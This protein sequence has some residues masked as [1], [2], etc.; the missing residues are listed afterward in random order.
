MKTKVKP[1]KYNM[2]IQSNGTEF[3][4]M[5]DC[6]GGNC[7]ICGW[8]PDVDKERKKNICKAFHP[9]VRRFIIGKGSFENI[10]RCP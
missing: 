4:R 9:T 7:L 6:D 10:Q 2:K 5:V 3:V 8:N 1:C